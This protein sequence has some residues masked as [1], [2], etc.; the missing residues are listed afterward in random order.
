M[1]TVVE[2]KHKNLLFYDIEAFKYYWC[3]VVVDE[4][5][6][7]RH[8]FEDVESLRKFY[9][10]HYKTHTWVGYN[11][12]QY[13]QVML[14]FIMLGADPYE[15][16]Y[17]LI[18]IGKKY[19]EFPH[20]LVEQ[21]KRLPLKNYD[22]VL[23]NKGLK[24]L[25]AFRGSMIKESS[26]DWN[27][28]EPLTREQKDE[29]IAYCT[30]DVLECRKVFYD[31]IEEYESHIA[32][33][34]TFK[35][36]PYMV[37]KTKAQLVAAILGAKKKTWFDEWDF[38]IVDTLKVEKY[39][40][41]VDWYLNPDNHDYKK[42]LNIEVAGVPHTFKWGGLHGARL[43]Y[44]GEGYFLN[45]DVASYY[46]ALMIEYGFL[47][48]NVPNPA[49]YKQIRD[50]RIILKKNKD[51]KQYPYKIVLNSTFGAQKD[52]F[53]NLYDPKQANNICVNGQLLLLD[54]IE[55]V[56]PYCD[57]IQ[58]NTDGILVKLHANNDEEAQEQKALIESIAGEWMARTRM[59]LEFDFVHKVFQKDVNNYLTV[60][61]KGKVK[62]KG[63]Y[64]KELS[65]LDYDLPIVNEAIVAYMVHGTPIEDT[66]N[67]C[68]ELIKFQKIVMVS[69]KYKHALHGKPREIK[70]K[71]NKS[72]KKKLE[73]TN[74]CTII[75]DKHLRVFASTNPEHGG[76][77]KVHA[78][79]NNINKVGDTPDNAFIINEDITGVTIENYPLDKEYYI[80]MAKKRLKG[81]YSKNEQ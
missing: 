80:K 44:N 1:S 76:I 45:M 69:A 31:T 67:A 58:S 74:E 10:E 46:P 15:C 70:W 11:S 41:I 32:L 3:V 37:S 13:D 56:E 52:K 78:Q 22:C 12:R 64:V 79:R 57:L 73:A 71:E 65:T 62:T 55:K 19:F 2:K 8:V 60:D 72:W 48:R 54:L 21:Y 14:R 18:N 43:S 9:K 66:I 20:H 77:Y 63:A 68:N 49:V 16:S 28:D 50:E 59:D 42:E 61:A 17:D 38:T 29:I 51:P 35:L 30:H 5:N 26:I 7:T 53:N 24:K 6:E 33:I 34:E 4:D 81:Y 39:K 23:L 25:E 40:H 75:K 47:S 27:Y 36:D